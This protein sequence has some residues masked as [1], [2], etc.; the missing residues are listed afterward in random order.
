[1]VNNNYYANFLANK[2]S[3]QKRFG[4][5]EKLI[6]VYLRT[7]IEVF[8]HQI[9]A[10]TFAVS[11]PLSKGY[12]LCDEV[13]LGKAIEAMLVVSQYYY[14]G[15][16]KIA[17]VVPAVLI[18][19]WTVAVEKQFK[20][21]AK[22]IKNAY[23]LSVIG[24]NIAIVSYDLANKLCDAFKAVA[25]DLVVFEE[26][27]CLRKY[28]IKENKTAVNLA[29]AFEGRKKLLL[30]AT[31]MCSSV[32]DLFGLIG[33]IDESIFPDQA[34]FYKRYYK[35]PENY[36]ELRERIAPFTFRTLRNQVKISAKLTERTVHTQVYSLSQNERQLY[37]TL[38]NY[39]AKPKKAAFPEMDSYELNLMLYKLLSSSVFAFS[40]T[41]SGIIARL[42][43][44]ESPEA[45][46]EC[47]EVKAMLSLASCM[48][49]TGKGE[50]FYK[51]LK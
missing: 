44:I 1:M 48:T 5:L 16:T 45:K 3:A 50:R 29:N 24:E 47:D 36:A 39:I 10:A 20:L 21:D 25:W 12:I 28:R 34:E 17:F 46:K 22:V 42:S 26:A 43:K 19:Q 27:H 40:K 23:D 41:L 4:D 9:A 37:S 51:L 15:K 11:N 18:G 13:E 35:K 31:P 2:L 8:P 32:M 49:F 14:S 38:E 7:G 33:F 6:P 30:T